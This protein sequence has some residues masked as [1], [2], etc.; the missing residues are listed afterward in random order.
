[1]DYSNTNLKEV[2]M[3][4]T[5]SEGTNMS[6]NSTFNTTQSSFGDFDDDTK[7]EKILAFLRVHDIFATQVGNGGDKSRS[8][9]PKGNGDLYQ[10]RKAAKYYI[11]SADD[12]AFAFWQV[13]AAAYGAGLE[14]DAWSGALHYMGRNTNMKRLIADLEAVLERS[15]P[16][17]SEGFYEGQLNRLVDNRTFMPVQG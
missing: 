12:K 10:A 7:R 15:K 1:M 3:L 2:D 11:Q 13:F 16:K 14:K 8:D 4:N 9:D 5:N 17:A 6:D